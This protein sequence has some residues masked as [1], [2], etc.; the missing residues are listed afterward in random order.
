[1]RNLAAQYQ[2]PLVCFGI[3]DVKGDS[4]QG[5]SFGTTSWV[6]LFKRSVF[7]VGQRKPQTPVPCSLGLFWR[8]RLLKFVKKRES[9]LCMPLAV[10]QIK[11]GYSTLAKQGTN[12]HKHRKEITTSKNAE[13]KQ[14]SIESLYSILKKIQI[15]TKGSVVASVHQWEFRCVQYIYLFHTCF[16]H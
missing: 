6:L 16:H 11:G 1:M 9:K 2:I 10:V 5:R 3:C 15:P 4:S 8:E 13:H 12:M 14:D 7:K